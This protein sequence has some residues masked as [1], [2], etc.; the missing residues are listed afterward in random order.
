MRRVQAEGVL[1]HEHQAAA[2]PRRFV[3]RAGAQS[4]EIPVTIG[5]DPPFPT[6]PPDGSLRKA[7]QEAQPGDTIRLARSLIVNLLEDITVLPGLDGLVITGPEEGDGTAQ[8]RA[9]IEGGDF[10]TQLES[11]NVRSNNVTVRNLQFRDLA[12]KVGFPG[13]GAATITGVKVQNCV[14]T[15][16]GLLDFDNV[17]DGRVEMNHFEL[18]QS[19]SASKEALSFTSTSGCTALKNV[20]EIGKKVDAITA[21]SDVNLTLQENMGTG[22]YFLQ[23]KTATLRGNVLTKSRLKVDTFSSPDRVTCSSSSTNAAS[24][25]RRAST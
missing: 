5:S 25:T 1:P 11:I 3:V 14:F 7:L 16:A 15:K 19:V 21:Q 17:I 9:K 13:S 4:R 23:P 20:F 2:I 12:V 24:C 8:I 22:D 18:T 6:P 10:K